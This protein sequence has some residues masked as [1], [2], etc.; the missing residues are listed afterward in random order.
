MT[1]ELQTG[2]KPPRSFQRIDCDRLIRLNLTRFAGF[3][4][5]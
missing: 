1:L 5:N 4:A 3:Q 2:G